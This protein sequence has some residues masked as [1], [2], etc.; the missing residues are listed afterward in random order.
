[1]TTY[2]VSEVVRSEEIQG[3]C[4]SGQCEYIVEHGVE[5]VH[6]RKVCRLIDEVTATDMSTRQW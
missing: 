4:N 1:V 2:L 3:G 6:E 5:H